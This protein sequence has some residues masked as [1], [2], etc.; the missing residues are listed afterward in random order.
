[1]EARE[2]IQITHKNKKIDS[3]NFLFKIDCIISSINVEKVLRLPKKP[4][5]K[6]RLKLPIVEKP[7]Y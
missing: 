4:I 3:L 1:M 6:K 2:K 5:T 7:E